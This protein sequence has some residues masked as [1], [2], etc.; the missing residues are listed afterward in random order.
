[1]GYATFVVIKHVQWSHVDG[2]NH[3]SPSICKTIP[4]PASAQVES[5]I[6]AG[7]VQEKQSNRWKETGGHGEQLGAGASR[8]PLPPIKEFIFF[9]EYE[10]DN[11][12]RKS[13]TVK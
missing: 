6:C 8:T 2:I 11:V 7:W 4:I 5:A 12:S 10:A 13:S 9:W 3:C 1:M